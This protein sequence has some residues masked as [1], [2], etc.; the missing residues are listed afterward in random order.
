VKSQ[1]QTRI[2]VQLSTDEARSAVTDATDL[3]LSIRSALY[4]LDGEPV[5]LL[6][7][8]PAQLLPPKKK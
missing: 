4:A 7:P 3:Q 2:I 6:R 8:A 5:Q 1:V